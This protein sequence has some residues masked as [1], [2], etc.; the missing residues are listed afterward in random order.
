MPA[1][2]SGGIHYASENKNSDRLSKHGAIPGGGV[3]APG[4]QV[5]GTAVVWEQQKKI[6]CSLGVHVLKTSE[7]F[8]KARL[9]F[10]MARPF[11]SFLSLILLLLR[12]SPSNSRLVSPFVSRLLNSSLSVRLA[13]DQRRQEKTGVRKKTLREDRGGEQ[14]SGGQAQGTLRSCSRTFQNRKI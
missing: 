2:G 11:V 3:S 5:G 7:P 6:I 14:G 1:L 8:L 9:W 12:S 13:D 4:S 10:L